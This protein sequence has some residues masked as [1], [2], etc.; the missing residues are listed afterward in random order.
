[1]IVGRQRS[2]VRRLRFI[3]NQPVPSWFRDVDR[4]TFLH[5]RAKLDALREQLR[6]MQRFRQNPADFLAETERL[7]ADSD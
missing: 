6:N 4:Q 2:A 7:W 5:E 1:M 3:E